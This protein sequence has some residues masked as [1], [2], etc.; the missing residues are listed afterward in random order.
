[1]AME[2]RRLVVR[3]SGKDIRDAIHEADIP[4]LRRLAIILYAL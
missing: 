2:S 3:A 4:A 1:M